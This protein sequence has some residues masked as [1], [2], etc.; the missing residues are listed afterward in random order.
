MITRWDSPHLSLQCARIPARMPCECYK[1]YEFLSSE[2]AL[3]MIEQDQEGKQKRNDQER[4]PEKAYCFAIVGM[5][6]G[7]Q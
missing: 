1:R 7:R 2:L 4:L 5:V 3:G 6:I